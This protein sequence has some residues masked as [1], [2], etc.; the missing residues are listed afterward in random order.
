M[1]RD[2]DSGR[3]KGGKAGFKNPY[4]GPSYRMPRGHEHI[5][6]VFLSAF[7]DIFS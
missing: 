6:F 4:C 3:I 5:L 2:R 1:G 7:R